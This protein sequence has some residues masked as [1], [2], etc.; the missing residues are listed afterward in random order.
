MGQT[1]KHKS[2]ISYKN[3]GWLSRTVSMQR[4]I[5]LGC[6][7]SGLLYILVTEVL[8][9]KIKENYNICGF[10]LPNMMNEIKSVQHADEF[11]MTLKKEIHLKWTRDYQII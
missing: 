4:R 6:P 3:N 11:T 8:A 2:D 10:S 7:V 9:I 1:S 5:R